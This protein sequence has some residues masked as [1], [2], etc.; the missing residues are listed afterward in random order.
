MDHAVPLRLVGTLHLIGALIES[1]I[2]LEDVGPVA[3]NHLLPDEAL[4]INISVTH[5]SRTP[6]NSA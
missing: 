3:A 5:C 2:G 4:I 1:Q 6:T